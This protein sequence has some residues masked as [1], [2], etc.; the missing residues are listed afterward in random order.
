MT[1]DPKT[2]TPITARFETPLGGIMTR[3]VGAITG[4]VEVWID[5]AHADTALIRYDGAED[6][7]TITGTT[8]GRSF[9]DIVTILTT[10]PGVDADGN[11]RT[12]DLT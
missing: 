7:Y 9:D 6:V 11:P 5:P 4:P 1:T 10:D 8:N 12:T 2:V 3:E